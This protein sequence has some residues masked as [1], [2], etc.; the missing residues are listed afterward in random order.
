MPCHMQ[1][2][3]YSWGHHL[4]STDCS[5]S[6]I[7]KEGGIPAPTHGSR[8][9]YPSHPCYSCCLLFSCATLGLC[10]TIVKGASLGRPLASGKT[11]NLGYIE[12][13]GSLP[14]HSPLHSQILFRVSLGLLGGR[15]QVLLS[16]LLLALHCAGHA[17]HLCFGT[18]TTNPLQIMPPDACALSHPDDRAVEDVGGGGLGLRPC[19]TRHLSLS[20]ACVIPTCRR[21]PESVPGLSCAGLS[22]P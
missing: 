11:R 5:A 15:K 2:E 4:P 18:S 13:E 1:R 16:G 22:V 14:S 6:A 19:L 10:R 7:W 17:P 3:P 21:Q 20:C 9:P 8:T 12:V